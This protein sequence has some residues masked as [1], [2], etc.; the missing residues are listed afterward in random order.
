MCDSFIEFL[1]ISKALGISEEE[2]R[3][4]YNN[5][6]A[7]LEQIRLGSP[8]VTAM[9]EFMSTIPGRSITD[10][11]TNIHSAVLQNFSGDKKLLP[12]SAS[13]FTNLL[14]KEHAAL[15]KVKIR[16]NINDTGAK[17]TMITIIK[18]K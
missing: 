6:K 10:T 7:E 1:A 16:V 18:K 11:A 4:I 12:N 14:D 5:N 9:Q 15:L 17:G 3:R 13:H 8:I 2:F